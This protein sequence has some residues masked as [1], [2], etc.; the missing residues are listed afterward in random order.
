MK[1]STKS[2]I[3]APYNCEN[4][5]GCP[6]LKSAARKETGI[7]GSEEE[8]TNCPVSGKSKETGAKA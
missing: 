1:T 7:K 3:E 4:C 5:G 8:G 2:G 6:D